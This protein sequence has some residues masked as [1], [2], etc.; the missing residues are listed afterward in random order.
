MAITI[1]SAPESYA[2]MHGD[3]WHVVSSNNYTQTGFRYVF[4]IT[5]SSETTRIKLYPDPVSG[6]GLFNAAAIVRQYVSSYFNPAT[7]PTAFSYN[8]AGILVNYSISFGEE[9]GGTLYTALNSGSYNAYNF[10]NPIFRD[11][12]TSYLGTFVGKWISN[13]SKNMLD[14]V[15]GERLFMSW[16]NASATNM[17]LT[18]QQ[19]TESGAATGSTLTGSIV[20]GSNI[21]MIDLSPTALNTYLGSALLSTSTYAYGVKVNGGNEARVTLNC[22]AKFTPATLHFLNALGGYDSFTFRLA[23][24]QSIEG[25]RKSMESLPWTLQSG[26]M[27]KFDTFRKINPGTIS[28]SVKQ[29]VRYKL[30]SDYITAADYNW[31]RELIF[32]PEVYLEQSGYYYPVM[33][34]D[35]SW[36]EKLRVDK[37]V[38]LTLQIEL[39][40][41]NS[42]YR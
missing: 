25:E 36:E 15:Y 20:S 6:K 22:N 24:R 14:V 19:Y 38:N 31:L 8:G 7:T 35:S 32:S 12:S 1:D 42:Q 4:D 28:Y 13:R 26:S 30:V 39:G 16:L 33:I 21:V 17:Q 3:L 5:I 27:K 37:V 18:V 40:N 9:Y 34:K 23:N 2:S 10:Y 29:S 11:P 41:I